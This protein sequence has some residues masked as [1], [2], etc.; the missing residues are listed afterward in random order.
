MTLREAAIRAISVGDIF[1]A[2]SPN[3]ASLIC[4]A[5]NVSNDDIEARTVTT[6]IHLRFSRSDGSSM[7]GTENIPCTIDSVEILPATIYETLLQLD[8]KFRIE[9]DVNRAKLTRSDMDALMFVNDHY[10]SHKLPDD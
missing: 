6:Q 5:T 8:D 3:R 2:V 7:L 10:L 9:P 1:H 4:L